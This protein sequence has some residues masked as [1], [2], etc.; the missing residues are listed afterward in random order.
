MTNPLTTIQA[1][2]TAAGITAVIEVG[3]EQELNVVLSNQTDFPLL[4]LVKVGVDGKRRFLR[5][6]GPVGF[7]LKWECVAYLLTKSNLDDTGAVR[8]TANY[9]LM[10]KAAEIVAILQSQGDTA[11]QMEQPQEL[12]FSVLPYNFFDLNLDGVILRVTFPDTYNY[13]PA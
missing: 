1:A 12:T 7:N 13:C 11:L 2:A 9:T 8:H 10:Q 5:P 3:D 4:A 6:G